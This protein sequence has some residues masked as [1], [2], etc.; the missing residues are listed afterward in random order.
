MEQGEPAPHSGS[1][2]G[3]GSMGL[4]K[5]LALG[6]LALVGLDFLLGGSAEVTATAEIT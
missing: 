2:N 5:K 4:G 3:K 6:A 1:E